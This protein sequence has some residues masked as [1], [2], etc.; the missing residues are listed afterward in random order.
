MSVLVLDNSVVLAWCLADERH[1]LAERAMDL[2]LERGAVVPG[3]WWYEL[4]N[5]LIVNEKRGRLSAEDTR[6]TLADLD[7][8]NITADSRHDTPT[9]LG[10]ARRHELSVY[11]TVYLE[12]ALRRGLP[13]ASLDRRLSQAATASGADSL[14]VE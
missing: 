2:T 3:V 5:A 8:M 7:E 13:L 9:V 1:P 12:V 11:D 10:L 4:R 6:A 14:A